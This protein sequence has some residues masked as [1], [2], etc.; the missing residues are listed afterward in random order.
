LPTLILI[1]GP[2]GAGKTTFANEIL[3]TDLKGVRF[4]NA[5]EIARGLSPF[6]PASVALKAGRILLHEVDELIGS[7]TSFALESTLS[8]RTHAAM[9]TRA[10]SA[11]FVVLLHFLWLPSPEESIARV[12]NRVKMGGHFVPSQD[13][14]RRY[15]RILENLVHLYLPAADEWF[16][17]DAS[18]FPPRALASSGSHAISDVSRFIHP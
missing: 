15:P 13:I 1:A 8:G 16:C 10:K 4:V 6:D 5:D 17:W 3:T 14:R 2:N 9:L 18:E 7:G 12:R 11:G